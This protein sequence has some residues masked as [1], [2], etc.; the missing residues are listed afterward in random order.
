[1][2]L[3][4]QRNGKPMTL[5]VGIAD[6]TKIYN[7]IAGN[8]DNN[9]GPDAG[10]V[11]QNKLG[12]TVQP[13][14]PSVANHLNLKGGVTITSVTPGSFADEIGLPNNS[15]I[16]EINRHPVIDEQSY[17][18]IVSALKTGDDVVF[19][20]RDPQGRNPGNM[21]VGGTLP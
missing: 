9:N 20:V 5:E 3:G 2:R 17:R 18:S 6:R 13:V 1:V 21:Y 12:I 4:I 15:I 11:G 7:S 10:D 19:V 16:T 14:S 8:N